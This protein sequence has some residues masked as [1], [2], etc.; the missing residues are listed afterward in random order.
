MDLH[1]DIITNS[2]RWSTTIHS[3][4]LVMTTE[5]IHF[6]KNGC[7]EGTSVWL[8]AV[9]VLQ[10]IV[11]VCACVGLLFNLAN[12]IIIIISNLC[13]KTMYKLLISQAASNAMTAL[14]YVMTHI[15]LLLLE[16]GSPAE[17]IIRICCYNLV[18]IGSMACAFTY[19]LISLELYY[20]VI[21]PF[22]HRESGCA[23]NVALVLL[24]IVS[25][26][27][28]ESIQI[29]VPLSRKQPY[30]TSMEAIVRLNDNT[31]L[32]IST[33][34]A[35]V[36]LIVIVYLNVVSLMAVHHSLRTKA[37]GGKGIK[38]STIT[39]AAMITTYIIFYLPNLIYGVL[40]LLQYESIIS[41]L[42]S[43]TPDRTKFLVTCLSNLHIMNTIAD[44]VVY[45]VRIDVIRDT[46]KRLIMKLK[47]H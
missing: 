15:S 36:C 8:C 39:I 7:D 22:K 18:H 25:I 20:K 30:E 34:I 19:T 32:F 2:E 46:Y 29:I 12:I 16:G 14:T 43:V 6:R 31:P 13:K 5:S 17:L 35:L 3:T 38:K 28:T 10:K 4:S 24:W 47:C 11:F 44:P 37:H 27:L 21:L 26:I 41:F 40:S 45:V 23:F 1:A 9:Y 42:P 33:G